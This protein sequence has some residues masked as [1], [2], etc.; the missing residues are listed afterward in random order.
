MATTKLHSAQTE[1][2]ELVFKHVEDLDICMDI[3]V[4]DKATKENPVPVLLW[5]HG[6]GLLQGTRKAVAPHMLSAPERHNLCLVSPDYRLAPQ[7]RMPG[8]LSDVKSATDF[9]HTH[10]FAAAT[11]HRVDSSRVVLSG[12]SAGGWL[13]LLAG[14]GIGFE[15]CGLDIPRPVRGIAAIYPITDLLDPFWKTKQHPVSY[16]DRVIDSSEVEPFINPTAPKTCSSPGDGAR[17]MFY[18]YMVQEGILSSLLL[19][20]TGIPE[21]AFSIARALRLGKIDPP[22]IYIITGNQDGKVS[23]RQSLDVVAALKDIDAGVDYHELVADHGFDKEPIYRMDSLYRFFHDA[24][25]A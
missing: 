23:Y 15:A 25:R 21:N 17:A 6:G 3:Y 1:P 7:T 11:G 12:S 22:P 13:C 4:P 10:E 24:C 18:H 14:T 20:G 16:M 9:L 5:W 8:I 19:D 2:I